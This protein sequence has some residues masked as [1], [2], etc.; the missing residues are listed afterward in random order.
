MYAHSL[1]GKALHK[2][3]HMLDNCYRGSKLAALA[4]RLS[5]FLSRT[6]NN[7]RLAQLFWFRDVSLPAWQHSLLS[8][9]FF[10]VQ[11]LGKKCFLLLSR[12][13]AAALPV[14]TACRLYNFILSRPCLLFLLLGALG[15]AAFSFLSPPRA[16]LL[17]V[18][19]AVG[20]LLM[21]K[22]A[23]GL[24]LLS[25]SLP[26][27]PNEA[28]LLLAILAGISFFAHRLRT[29]NLTLLPLSIEPALVLYLFVAVVA[30]LASATFTGSLRDL[31]IY[32]CSF[33]VF[34]V[35]INQLQT[36]KEL[37]TYLNFALA[38]ALLV[39]LYGIYQYIFGAPMQSGWVDAT[40]NPLI[41]VRV[42]S[43]FGNPNVMAEYLILIIP[44]GIAL[45][46]SVRNIFCKLL[47]LGVTGLLALSL[48]LTLS[49]GGALGLL[50]ALFIFALLKDRRIIIVL[51]LVVLIAAAVMPAVFLQRFATIGNPM[52]S[53]NA[54]RLT[55][56]KETVQMI[57]DFPLTGVGLGY[58]AYQKVYPYYMLDRTKR[59]F[60]SHNTALQS[61]AETG[62]IG[63]LAFF[64]LM[65]GAGKRGLQAL[66]RSDDN[67]LKHITMAALAALAGIL[68]QG[69]GEVIIYLPKITML[70]WLTVALI[71]LALKLDQKET[72]S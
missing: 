68:T 30:T 67:Y 29:G 20:L 65:A 54:Y 39:A 31:A 28:L 48:L 26:V 52:D 15:A 17:P 55:V 61:L 37:H 53:S 62:I 58:Q 49:R 32:I 36:K 71:F 47:Y 7:S 66:R 16:L 11:E 42:Y 21:H 63:F 8:R 9:L 64:W 34:F 2:T 51:L 24:Y 57:K 41:G 45:F 43:F 13:L 5:A 38:G 69:L 50:A 70:F 44:F 25:A 60:H 56:W 40:R 4:D 35:L 1:T 6:F 18:A 19:A 12:L 46:F 14:S 10:F 22:P 3:A 33:L 23:W 27:I 72:V 59:P